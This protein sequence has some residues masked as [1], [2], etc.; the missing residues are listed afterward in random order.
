MLIF[1][2]HLSN[3]VDLGH[4]DLLFHRRR[5]QNPNAFF[6]LTDIAPELVFP[7]GETCHVGR[8]RALLL[9]QNNIVYR[10][11]ME[12][13]H[14]LQILTEIIAVEHV[15]D[16]LFN[17]VSNLF[18]PVL[19]G[20]FFCHDQASCH[21]HVTLLDAI[22]ERGRQFIFRPR[23]QAKKSLQRKH[24]LFQKRDIF[25]LLRAFRIRAFLV[26]CSLAQGSQYLLLGPVGT[27]NILQISQ[28]RF[29][30]FGDRTS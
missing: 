18:D 14:G 25:A 9:N 21:M 5:C 30:A 19:L 17:A 28:C 11:V 3:R 20:L 27:N 2:S 6:A 15:F 10:I 16:A 22:F 1:C 13:A 8:I 26:F 4:L 29:C 12:P 24:F 23:S 7:L